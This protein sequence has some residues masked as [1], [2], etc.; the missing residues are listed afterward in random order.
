MRD[1]S[2]AIVKRMVNNKYVG[3]VLMTL[4]MCF[5]SSF[6]SY[7]RAQRALGTN[8]GNAPVIE[9]TVSA[10]I[11]DG[12]AN[13][14]KIAAAN[15]PAT[16]YYW[17]DT[18]FGPLPTLIN[19]VGR[20]TVA[21]QMVMEG[22]RMGWR[23]QLN[24]AATEQEI[25]CLYFSAHENA[26][27]EIRPYVCKPT[28]SDTTATACASF[29]W[30]GIA[31]A[32]S[33]DYADTLKNTA[34][35]DSIITLHLTINHST[36][37]EETLTACDSLYWNGE[38]YKESGD[39]IYTTTN[40]AGC[41]S[42]ATL[43]LTIHHSVSVTLKDTTVCESYRWVDT[44]IYTSGTYTR[45]LKTTNGCDS[46]VTQTVTINY[47]VEQ[48]VKVTAYDQYTWIDNKT[49]TESIVGPGW[50]LETV[51]GCDSTLT[52]HLTI[53]HLHKDTVHHSVCQADL[54]YVWNGESY[55]KAG[56]YNADTIFV[57]AV[58]TLRTLDLTVLQPTTGDTIAEARGSFVWQGK[59]YIESGEYTHT[60][61]GG[62]AAG[63]DSIVT[64]YLTL[65]HD[66]MLVYYCPQSG[67]EEHIDL[68]SDPRLW[69]TPYEYEKPSKDWYMDSVVVDESN[70]GAYVDF[71]KAEQ[72]LQEYYVEPLTPVTAIY[73]RYR[74]RGA[75]SQTEVVINRTQ[76]QWVETGTVSIEVQ[77]QCG[78]RY[79]D[80]FTVGNMTESTEQVSGE[81][82][83]IKRVENG[84][85]VI[86]RN[87]AKYTIL[88]TKI[89]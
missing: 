4:V 36:T 6:F 25:R 74:E 12:T 57:T 18:A 87:G 47:S 83:A 77:F 63:C 85:V 58:D 17:P 62:N 30:K 88:G 64:L 21:S 49:Y 41:D 37:G 79:Y 84:Q 10:N 31:Y 15:L 45:A 86:I 50:S 32:E 2:Y 53:K 82:Q 28:T 34:G 46:V 23:W 35:C 20:D 14:F 43:H 66:T 8:A 56:L 70:S 81:E 16:V 80:S 55:D 65:A 38:W 22:C 52:L 42:T 26:S 9:D 72:N 69:Y 1:F 59:T 54:P 48:Q 51:A 71:L 29:T 3:R 24:A 68:T 33:G 67:I 19:V 39:Y 78:Q 89:Q 73:W 40:A 76:P 13:Y 60:I 61:V 27:A 5:I 11:V 7:A 75:S 44:T